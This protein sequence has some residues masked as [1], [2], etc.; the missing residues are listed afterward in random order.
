MTEPSIVE[1]EAQPYVGI[2][3]S[4]P[5]DGIPA[6]ADRLRDIFG[7]LASRGVAP[8]GAPFLKYNVVAMESGLE[9]EAGVPVGPGV[10]GEGD[11]VAGLL[12]AGRYAT[13]T[14]VG[15]PSEL[16]DATARL[17][18][19][20]AAR[21]LEWDLS[22]A[23]RWTARLEIYHTDPAEEPDMTKWET[24]LAFRLA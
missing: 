9:M 23:G 24:E 18:E 2:S 11:I 19:W 21:G 14:H 12:P 3:A 1:R 16:V 15:H 10:D 13:L 7:W 8:A 22:P 4:V 17:L 6:I 5:M 20:A